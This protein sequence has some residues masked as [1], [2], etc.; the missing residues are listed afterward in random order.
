VHLVREVFSPRCSQ[1]EGAESKRESD[2]EERCES[3]SLLLSK[4]LKEL[5]FPEDLTLL[6]R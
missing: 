2:E 1:R 3:R 6:N 5:V 4:Y